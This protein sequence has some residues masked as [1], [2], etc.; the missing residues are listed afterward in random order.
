MREP[1]FWWGAP[2]TAARLLMP[3][4]AV[5]GAVAAW[6][7][8][9]GG[10]R[11]TA[12][13]F[14]IGNLTVGGAGKTPTALTVARMLTAAGERP[15]FLTRGYGGTLAGPLQVDP[16]RHRA[17][18]VGDEPLLLARVAPTIVGRDRVAGGKMAVADGASVIV[19]D[20]GF[21]NPGLDKDFSVLVVDA[22]RGIGNGLVIPAGPL[23]APVAAQLARA[24]AIVVVGISTSDK[25]IEREARVFKLPIFGARLQPEAGA[26]AALAGRQVLAFAGIADPDKFFATLA[27]AGAEVVAKRRFPDHHR[28]TPAEAKALCEDADHAGLILVTTQKDI[29]RLTGEDRPAALVARSQALP[30]TLVFDD[31]VGFKR[32]LIESLVAAKERST[33][34]IR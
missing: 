4:A 30:V 13:V 31:E 32:L 34:A 3:L 20:D 1:E 10:H 7:L 16:A 19:M 27:D 2:R 12:P 24:Q 18:E 23:R 29:A 11:L 14:C 33:Q 21:Q 8:G 17:S 15:I 22:R 9:W 5:Y 28:Y 26:A 6:R 25:Q